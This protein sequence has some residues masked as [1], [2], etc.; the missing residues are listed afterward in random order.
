MWVWDVYKH[1]MYMYEVW[2]F[3]D[4]KLEKKITNCM[5]EKVWGGGLLHGPSNKNPWVEVKL[6]S[7]NSSTPE[8]DLINNFIEGEFKECFTFGDMC[9]QY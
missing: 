1:E 9:M 6:M 3:R 8:S 2:G 7:T 5:T 4:E